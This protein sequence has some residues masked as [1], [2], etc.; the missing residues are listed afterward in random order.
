GQNCAELGI[1]TIT[2]SG[3][4]FRLGDAAAERPVPFLEKP[5]RF[6]DLQCVLGAVADYSRPA[7]RAQGGEPR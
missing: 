7:S 6:A 2:L 5:F 4:E 3:R 1:P